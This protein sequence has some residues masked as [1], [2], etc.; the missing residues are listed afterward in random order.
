MM[1]LDALSQKDIITV[2]ADKLNS[3]LSTFSLDESVW[4]FDFDGTLIHKWFNSFAPIDH[5]DLDSEWVLVAMKQYMI[6][7]E[8]SRSY[9]ELESSLISEDLILPQ[10]ALRM[11]EQLDF[12]SF[13]NKQMN[14]WWD[15]TMK[16]A[17]ERS[18]PMAT[19]DLTDLSWRPWAKKLI[20]DLLERK[21]QVLIISSGIGN[22]IRYAIQASGF[23]LDHPCLHIKSNDFITDKNG[24]CS[25]YDPDLITPFTKMHV[26]YHK[27]GIS[28]KKFAI[29]A[30]DSLGDAH[31]V[32]EHF[33]PSTLINIGFT[34]GKEYKNNTFPDVFDVVFT[35]KDSSFDAVAEVFLHNTTNLEK[36]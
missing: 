26:D 18:V 6:C 30:G 19:F 12:E 11:K 17:V 13:K 25:D 33:E 8:N 10:A 9:E 36:K 7:I 24:F 23:D 3:F 27:Y 20:Q 21:V 14:H 16:K 2:N 29:Q 22:L 5:C 34:N 31:M 15:F 28:D 4:V 32:T 35:Q 1:T